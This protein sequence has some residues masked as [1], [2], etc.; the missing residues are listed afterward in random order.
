MKFVYLLCLT[1]F[2]LLVKYSN[3]LNC[4]V[5]LASGTSNSQIH[6]LQ[7]TIKFGQNFT[8]AV[9]GYQTEGSDVVDEHRLIYSHIQMW[10]NSDRV[11]PLDITNTGYAP[12]TYNPQIIMTS[13]LYAW[14]YQAG[15]VLKVTYTKLLD[16]PTQLWINGA[17][18]D[19]F[20]ITCSINSINA[21]E[22]ATYVDK[23]Q[24]DIIVFYFSHDLVNCSTNT[25]QITIGNSIKSMASDFFGFKNHPCDIA[26][27]PY[28][29]KYSGSTGVY[30]CI[31]NS[32]FA[33][34][35]STTAT[36][37]P[38]VYIFNNSICDARTLTPAV[39]KNGN[40]VT[41]LGSQTRYYVNID[42]Q[43]VYNDENL[44]SDHANLVD[45]RLRRNNDGIIDKLFMYT[46]QH[47]NCDDY[48][49]G[50]AIDL[51]I[52][53]QN[54]KLITFTASSPRDKVCVL[55]FIS[56]SISEENRGI[57]AKATGSVHNTTWI[58]LYQDNPTFNGYGDL[59]TLNAP[60]LYLMTSAQ[61]V[62]STKKHV[63]IYTTGY[64]VRED[65]KREFRIY[66]K[67]TSRTS[68]FIDYPIT[69]IN[70]TQVGEGADYVLESNCTLPGN[71]LYVGYFASHTATDADMYPAF[72]NGEV[73]VTDDDFIN[74]DSFQ[75]L[76]TG[77]K[78]GWVTGEV[79]GALCGV[80][81]IYLIIARLVKGRS[82]K[83]LFCPKD[84]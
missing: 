72:V 34:Q 13:D 75:N 45:N 69:H 57:T 51:Q 73:L 77:E 27:Y 65:D 10:R 79:V 47:V 17:V 32:S 46:K 59:V 76:P 68:G 55:S 25:S 16:S 43:Y 66:Q 23:P 81:L 6:T 84:K 5:S 11:Y 48:Y 53:T 19:S 33:K 36:Y 3:A 80:I 26:N 70:V 18:S 28:L 2:A 12:N 50:H 37:T 35:E 62:T 38:R 67:T 29:Q 56:T 52:Y 54:W 44:G 49:Y 42:Y 30:Y 8:Y 31:A 15:D 20:S 82:M 61:R 63:K 58:G 4:S 39:L 60:Q 71:D 24:Q 1:A 9:D 78:A 83:S 41:V 22:T 14:Q 40:S 7:W 74:H 21:L 64:I